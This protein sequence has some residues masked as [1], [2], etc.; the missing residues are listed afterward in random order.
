MI[1]V[2]LMQGEGNLVAALEK[3]LQEIKDEIPHGMVDEVQGSTIC[4]S[5]F[6]CFI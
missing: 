5:I 4:L 6:V 3:M 2:C 1:L